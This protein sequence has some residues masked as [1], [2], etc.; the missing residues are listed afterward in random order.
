MPI[1]PGPTRTAKEFSNGSRKPCPRSA[2]D[3][4]KIEKVSDTRARVE[5]HSAQ[6]NGHTCTVNG[7]ASL[8]G[9]ALVLMDEDSSDNPADRE[10][11]RA[12]LGGRTVT[13]D[14][15]NS[16]GQPAPFCG[17]RAN[18]ENIDFPLSARRKGT[19]KCAE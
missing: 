5:V 16:K 13:F 6:H 19:G 17:F 12:M 4:L 9:D 7:T 3:C 1:C 8:D 2:R 15:V 11:V 10:G 18:L 14:N